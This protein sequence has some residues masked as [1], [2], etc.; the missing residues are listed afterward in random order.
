MLQTLYFKFSASEESVYIFTKVGIE[1]WGRI[2]TG[3]AELL[4]SIL[5]IIPRSRFLGA[6][7]GAGIMLGAIASHFFLLGIEVMND[8]GYLFFLAWVVLLCC[9]W[10]LYVEKEKILRLFVRK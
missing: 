5:L 2:G 6:F 7:M 10:I 4:A 9:S 1:P 3:I 8:K